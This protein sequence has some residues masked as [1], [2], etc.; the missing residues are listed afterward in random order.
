MSKSW[1][2]I[3]A[4]LSLLGCAAAPRDVK[5]PIGEDKVVYHVNDTET[6]AANALRNI[7]N[8][9]EVNPQAKIVVVTHARGVDFLMTDAKDR[10]GNPYNIAVEQLKAQGVRFDICEITLRNRKLKKEQFIPEATFVPSGVAEIT[11]L[12]Q[13]EGYAYLRP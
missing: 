9:L 2:A 13:R 11:R 3:V 4:S 1:L 10:N 8:H 5:S 7:G 6:Q 12:Q